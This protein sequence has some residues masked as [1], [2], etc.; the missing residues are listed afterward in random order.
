MFKKAILFLMEWIWRLLCL[1]VVWI[2]FCLPIIT[3]IPATFTMCSVINKWMEEDKD[4]AIIPTFYREFR[5]IFLKSYP[6]GFAVCVI[7]IFF[8]IDWNILAG[9]DTAE[10]ITLRYSISVL[11][12]VYL[13]TALYS[14]P[15]FL[16][17]HFSWY[18]TLFI[19]LMV[20]VRQPFTSFVMLCGLLLVLLLVLLFT[21]AGVLVFGSLIALIISKIGRIGMIK[22]SHK[23]LNI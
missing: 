8:Y 2:M 21:G 15:V 20:A 11:A 23:F 19:S 17:Y 5:K 22:L 18:K 16:Q 7:G 13:T 3:V 6:T 10:L 9:S 12:I 14:I 1:N 4:L